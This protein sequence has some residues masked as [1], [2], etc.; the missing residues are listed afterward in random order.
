MAENVDDCRSHV[1]T[2]YAGKLE[3]EQIVSKAENVMAKQLEYLRSQENLTISCDGG[4]TRGREAFWTIHVSTPKRKV[5]LMECREATSDSHT[6]V[7]IKNLV[8]EVCCYVN[9]SDWLSADT[10]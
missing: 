8:L 10:F 1:H 5:Y 2:S 9:A 4:T 3:T 7:W 6:G